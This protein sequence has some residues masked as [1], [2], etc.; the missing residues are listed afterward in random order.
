MFDK[1]TD[2]YC[3]NK[4]SFVMIH[5]TKDQEE[6][7]TMLKLCDNLEAFVKVT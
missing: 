1:Y 4:L 3:V 7:E 6:N 2:I 5:C